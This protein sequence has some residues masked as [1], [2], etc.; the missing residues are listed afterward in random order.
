[1]SNEGVDMTTEVT[2]EAVQGD[3]LPARM[4][5]PDSMAAPDGRPRD[6]KT[7]ELI[8]A[9]NIPGKGQPEQP[10]GSFGV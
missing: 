2:R 7:L 9:A 8:A 10:P 6:E 4:G 3:D 5:A 1:M